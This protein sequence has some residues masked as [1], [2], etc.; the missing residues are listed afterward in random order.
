MQ[1][2][3]KNPNSDREKT[4]REKKHRK[5]KKKRKPLSQRRI[6]IWKEKERTKERCTVQVDSTD[7][8]NKNFL[9]NQTKRFAA[10]RCPGFNTTCAELEQELWRKQT[11]IN[12]DLFPKKVPSF[13]TGR[14]GLW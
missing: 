8:P 2:S 11:G 6:F 10:D 12:V 9:W 7:W 4:K 14:R 1:S 13:W 3:K 5:T